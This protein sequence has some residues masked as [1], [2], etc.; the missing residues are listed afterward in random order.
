MEI[1]LQK[2]NIEQLYN[3][4]INLR[5]EC[6]SGGIKSYYIRKIEEQYD[7]NFDKVI[8]NFEDEN[9][10]LLPY[11]K[12]YLFNSS[13][14]NCEEQVTDVLLN[15]GIFNG[16]RLEPNISDLLR[17]KYRNEFFKDGYSKKI[18]E[19]CPLYIEMLILL[20]NI[21]IVSLDEQ[22]KLLLE[23]KCEYKYLG[24]FIIEY[25]KNNKFIELYYIEK[26]IKLRVNKERLNELLNNDRL[27]C[28]YI[29]C[30]KG[31][32]NS[33]R[34]NEWFKLVSKIGYLQKKAD[35]WI[36]NNSCKLVSSKF[37]AIMAEC[38]IIDVSV[39]DGDNYISLTTFG[40]S[41][42]RNE[43]IKSWP[44]SNYRLYEKDRSFIAINDNPSVILSN[45]INNKL[46]YKGIILE[47]KLD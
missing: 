47:F 20:Y 32:F 17:K 42:S 28:F 37:I 29:D 33:L 19:K 25:L 45:L 35:V 34:Y 38:G 15:W 14:V 36:N 11:I 6:I 21:S 39:I 2:L 5:C 18:D 16:E 7:K 44:G 30:Y 22:D 26:S 4:T 27:L 10:D 8:K 23:F 3:I 24:N 41:L 13:V 40:L 12:L 9:I 43:L 46:M 1:F 31:I